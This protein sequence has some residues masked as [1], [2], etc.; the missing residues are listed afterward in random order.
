MN[1]AKQNSHNWDL[2]SF[3]QKDHRG[4]DIYFESQIGFWAIFEWNDNDELIGWE[5]TG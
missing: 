5:I 2:G 3:I 4:N 1:R